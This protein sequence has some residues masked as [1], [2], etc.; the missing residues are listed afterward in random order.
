MIY[1][2]LKFVET[3]DIND[4]PILKNIVEANNLFRG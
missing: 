4:Y 2:Y 3:K 1:G